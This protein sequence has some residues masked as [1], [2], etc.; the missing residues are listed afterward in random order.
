MKLDRL[1]AASTLAIFFIQVRAR[2]C[3]CR[4]CHTYS[5]RL[6]TCLHC[7]YFGC[8]E[9][10]HIHRHAQ[11][12]GHFLAMDLSYGQTYCFLCHENVY[13][14]EV[15]EIAQ[16]EWK[17]VCRFNGWCESLL[18][19]LPYWEPTG[20]ELEY[21]RLNPKRRKIAAD[22]YVGLRGLVNLGNTCFMNCIL[23]AFVHTPMLRDYFLAE[24]HECDKERC[25]VCEMTHLFQKFYAGERTA[26]VPFKLL[27]LVWTNARHLAGYEQQDAHEFLIAALD[28]LHQHL[29]SS[30]S[31]NDNNKLISGRPSLSR[32]SSE[33]LIINNLHE[34]VNEPDVNDDDSSSSGNPCDCIIDQ[35]FTGGWQSDVTCQR[36]GGVSTTIDPFWDISLD[37]PGSMSSPWHCMSPT[38]TSAP[39]MVSQVSGGNQINGSEQRPMSL[40]DC[41]NR[42]T[43]PE[44]LGSAA[45][46]KCSRCHSY[47]ESTK[48]LTLNKLPIVCC[49]HLKRFEHTNKARRKIPTYISFPMDLDLS[50]FMASRR[51]VNT[52]DETSFDEALRE[53]KYSLFAVVNHLGSLQSG[54]YSVYVRQH[55]DQWFQ[56]NDSTILKASK[57]EV[58]QSEA[59][60]LFYHK[61]Y[62]EYD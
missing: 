3:V 53:N 23:Q 44:H 7:I 55:R 1:S 10:K 41:L 54:H 43:R 59:Y 58:L 13:D 48:Q 29:S 2:S 62:L 8:Y 34:S 22:S 50:P 12:S 21:L 14:K 28:L 39:G 15:E 47:Q 16:K 45:K 25:L 18:P 61:Q 32:S 19:T 37:L 27:H 26:Y 30:E 56:C 38:Q 5:G 11:D 6:H 36:C 49:F 60:L 31:T 17:K 24:R 9:N 46:I 52:R 51:S 33:N 57:T 40:K 42:F 20:M 35:I 4:V